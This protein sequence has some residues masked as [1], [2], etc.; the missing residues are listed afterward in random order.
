MDIIVTGSF[1]TRSLFCD[2][3][4]RSPLKGNGEAH[5]R[6]AREDGAVLERAVRDKQTKYWDLEESSLADFVALVGEVGGRWHEDAV[7]WIRCLAKHKAKQ[8]H[9]LLKRSAELA[10]TDRWW[11]LVGATSQNALAASLLAP[12]GK[13]LILDDAAGFE[14]ELDSL[15]DAQ[16]WAGEAP[17]EREV[18]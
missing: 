13:K 11:A 2:A 1:L 14:P 16:R 12:C 9:P 3:R 15:L 10:W 8:Q 18:P 17:L 6:A 4:L 5:P 7:H